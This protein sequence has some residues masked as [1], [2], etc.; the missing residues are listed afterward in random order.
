MK[1]LCIILLVVVALS[2]MALSP[3]EQNKI[4]KARDLLNEVLKN[5]PAHKSWLGTNLSEIRHYGTNWPFRNIFKTASKWKEYSTSTYKPTNNP[6]NLDDNGWVRCLAPDTYAVASLLLQKPNY[7]AGEYVVTYEGE[8]KLLYRG[9]AS[10][11]DDLSTQGRDVL[12]VTPT[13]KGIS[14]LLM[15]TTEGNPIRNIK[16]YFPGEENNTG[17]FRQQYLDFLTGYGTLRFMDWM[18]TNEST[19]RLWEEHPKTTNSTYSSTA[20]VPAE[21]MCELANELGA[22]PWFCIPHQATDNYVIQFAKSVKDN[23]KIELTPYFEYTNEAWNGGFAQSA[24]CKNQGLALGLDTNPNRARAY[25]YSKRA[26]Q[27]FTLI[28]GVYEDTSRF[29]RVIATQAANLGVSRKVLTFEDAY[30]HADILAIAPYFG[31]GFGANDMT[32]P[33]LMDSLRDDAIPQSIHIMEMQK[34]LAEEYGLQLV[35]Y[36]GGQHLTAKKAQQKDTALNAL[37]DAANRSDEMEGLYIAYLNAWRKTTDGIFVHFN[38][39]GPFT[40]YGRWGSIEYLG[41]EL[42]PKARALRT[43][44]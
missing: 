27:I 41:Q 23:L 31:G 30:Q 42:G 38:E 13:N 17:T 18:R 16:V 24:Y 29:H 40:K 10:K 44:Q 14:L 28:E 37:L 11:N 21:V 2:A 7:P 9:A 34:A 19:L 33:Q 39:C 22:D 4:E 32:L 20:G 36:E 15:Q 43:L 35:A 5:E 3:E 1:R 8:G 25:Y 26:V 6:L 12:S